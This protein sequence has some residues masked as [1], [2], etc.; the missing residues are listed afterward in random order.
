VTA[1]SSP[2]DSARGA[3]LHLPVLDGIRGVAIVMVLCVHFIGDSPASTSP[4]HTL[5]KLYPFTG[6]SRDRVVA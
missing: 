5:V 2:A 4:G 3:P 1:E 6:S